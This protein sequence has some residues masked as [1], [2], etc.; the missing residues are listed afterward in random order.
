MTSLGCA[1]NLVDS[2]VMLGIL[3]SAGFEA[4]EH[5]D[6]AD[7]LI[8]NT[9]G[10]LEAS[11]EESCRAIDQLLREKKKGGKVVV[12]GCMVQKFGAEI[13]TRFPDV[14][15]F[16]GSGDMEKILEAVSAGEPGE[17]ISSNRSYLEWGEI[18]RQLSTPKNYAYLKIA[19]G[20]RKRCAFCIIPSIKGPLRS[21]ETS[22]VVKE[23]RSLLDRGVFEVILIAQDLGDFG[24]DRREKEAL[25]PLLQQMLADPRP[26][27]LRLLYLYPDEITDSLIACIRNDP[28]ICPYL[29]MPIQHISDPVLKAMRRTTSRRQITETLLKLRA[30]VP[31][32]VIR[33][34]LMVGF[35]GETD[36]QFEELLNFIEE[37][38]LDNVGIFKYSRE[39]ESHSASLPGH[40][41]DAVKEERFLRL[42][43]KQKELT[44]KRN[45]AYIGKKLEVMVEGYHPDYPVLMRGRF[46]GQ[47]PE[48]DGQVLINDGRKVR[49][50][51]RL[52]PVEITDVADY[53]LIGTVV[54]PKSSS[55]LSSKLCL[56]SS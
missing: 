24:K 9:C 23:F 17:E 43:T 4:T 19:E 52:Y 8:V 53:D 30:E 27:W 1:R 55:P 50:F 47:C 16:L 18:P 38:P 40:L 5:H 41:P 37:Y 11:R 49:A 12:A 36:A 54:A 3:L 33:T 42:A 25:V 2:E 29:D 6:K 15:Y 32:V 22:Q 56:V 20:C 39:E 14:H 26:F 35:P 7:Y 44:A 10:F 21:K 34:S 13:R 31:G 28:R 46:Y 51:G 45:R 48:I